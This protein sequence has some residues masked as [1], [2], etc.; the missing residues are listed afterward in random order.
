MAK[1]NHAFRPQSTIESILMLDNRTAEAVPTSGSSPMESVGA[2][3]SAAS[4]Y[5]LLV[6]TLINIFS[7]VDRIALSILMEAI[8]LD[9]H[10]SD[11][12]LGLLSGIAFA[13]F[14]A[15]LGIPLAALADRSSRVKLISACLALWSLMTAASGLAKNYPQLFLARMGVGIGE[16]GCVPPAH[17][18]IGDYFPREKRALGI[19]LFNA[20]AAVGVAGGM[21][22]VG[23]LGEKLGWRASM[24]IIGLMGVPLALLTITTLREPPRP[25]SSS[26]KETPFQSIAALLKRRAFVNL[27]IAF[28]LSQICTDGTSQWLPTYMIR[29]FGMGMAEIGAWIGL[30]T[31]A[32]GVLGV[33]AGGLTASTLLRHDPRWELWI[34]TI[35][36]TICIPLFATMALA[37]NVWVVLGMKTVITFFSAAGAGVATAAVQSFAEPHRRATAVAMFLFLAAL[38]GSGIG[39]YMIGLVSDLLAPTFG[40]ESLRYAMLIACVMLV[41]A[42]THYYLAS[43]GTLRDRIN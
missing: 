30:I 36:F 41:W 13:L 11:Q 18:L 23:M 37:P 15:I 14:Y 16:A 38:L 19:S 39:P 20:G 21:F 27:A 26:A 32:F 6:L 10:L 8:K 29:S 35:C 1:W 43:R 40:K 25:V 3:V 9:L 42:V 33:V 2:K 28:A 34:P 24:Q 5:A 4:W 7:F 31:A 17:S 12:Q 22:F